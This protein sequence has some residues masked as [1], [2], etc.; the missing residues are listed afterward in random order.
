MLNVIF[1]G[2][3]RFASGLLSAAEQI[4]GEQHNCIAIAI[5][6]PSTSSIAL[7]EQQCR[8]ALA[9]LDHLQGVVFFTDLLGG[10]PFRIASTLA[11]QNSHMKVEVLTGV[12]LQLA[13]EMLGERNGE[14]L[15]TFRQQALDCGRRGLTSLADELRK[16]SKPRWLDGAPGAGI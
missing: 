10:T 4:L 14:N 8:D 16:P 7:L 1:C 3:G 12:N 5:D 9:L 13:V 6:F 15:E 11:V 2:H